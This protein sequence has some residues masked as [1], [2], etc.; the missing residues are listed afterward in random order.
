MANPAARD[1]PNCWSSAIPNTEV[2]AA[3]GP[4]NHWFYLVSQGSNPPGG[5][6][7]PIC[8][9]GPSS[10]TGVG[11]V[12]AGQIYYN[13]LLAKTSTWRYA[14]VRLASLNAA[15]NMFG[16]GSAECTTVKAAWDA[17]SVPVQPGEPSCGGSPGTMVFSD[18]FET[19][20]T[21]WT[22]NPTTTD[23]ATTG[24]WVR[25]NPAGTSSGSVA[26][27]LDTTASGSNDLVTGAAGG[28][29]GTADID[30][31]VTSIQSPAIT[32]PSGSI[33]LSFAW[34]LAHLSNATS[35]DFFRVSVVTGTG[36]TTQVFQ[37]VGAATN[38]AGTW[39]TANVNLSGFAGQ[40]VRLRI[41]AA[42]AATASL[43]EA[44]VDDILI[45]V[46]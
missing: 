21:G 39:S 23:T 9:G 19:A 44:G 11:I 15:V 29:A 5:P 35:A 18:D 22:A 16:A 37:Q 24:Q 1:H 32:L 41:E 4:L 31:G 43:V 27:Q 45:T 13:A 42:D 8:P 10:V 20:A 12:T 34:Y 40:T 30:G 36:A 46:S 7:S 26:L 25:G 6:A 28:S 2:H 38:R 3:A 17:V 33:N 14:N